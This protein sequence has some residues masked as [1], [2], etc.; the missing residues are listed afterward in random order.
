MGC[1]CSSTEC[2]NGINEHEAKRIYKRVT[3]EEARAKFSRL[4]KEQQQDKVFDKRAI[5]LNFIV[6]PNRTNSA[7]LTRVVASK[8]F[9]ISNNLIDTKDAANLTMSTINSADGTYYIEYRHICKEISG[10]S[11]YDAIDILYTIALDGS[12]D[13]EVTKFLLPENTLRYFLLSPLC[14]SPRLTDE[15][16]PIPDNF[17]LGLD[18]QQHRLLFSPSAYPNKITIK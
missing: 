9:N 15:T 1:I 12:D 17:L 14:P 3:Y 7:N 6:M 13:D 11:L 18:L 5:S 4:T 10:A 2:I 8:S 16:I